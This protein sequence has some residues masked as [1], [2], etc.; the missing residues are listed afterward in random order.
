MLRSTDR[1]I[2]CLNAG[3]APAPLYLNFVEEVKSAYLA[4]MH[5]V[6]VGK[7]P[8]LLLA[9]ERLWSHATLT[10]PTAVY[11]SRVGVDGPTLTS[12]GGV[13]E[14]SGAVE[15]AVLI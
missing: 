9:E 10:P 14:I 11:A 7:Q 8:H 2:P 1:A 5:G 12:D 13:T 3:G 4:L 6:S 15:G